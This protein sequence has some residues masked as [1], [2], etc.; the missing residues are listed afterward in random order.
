MQGSVLE[1]ERSVDEES[2]QRD[3]AIDVPPFKS[4]EIYR[5][6]K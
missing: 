6:P 4:L 5:P 2:G 3:V 1:Y